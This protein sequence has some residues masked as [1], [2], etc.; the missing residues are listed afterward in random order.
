M[1][2]SEFVHQPKDTKKQRQEKAQSETIT[3]FAETENHKEINK[4]E[5]QRLKK[6]LEQIQKL[7][8]KDKIIKEKREMIHQ[9]QQVLE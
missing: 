1:S 5:A 6:S 2:I 8:G 3:E 9:Q 4:E 7:R